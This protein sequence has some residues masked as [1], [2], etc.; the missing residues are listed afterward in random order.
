LALHGGNAPLRLQNPDWKPI[1]HRRQIVQDFTG[2]RP[3]QRK[4][5]LR[6]LWNLLCKKDKNR[7]LGTQD[8]PGCRGGG[9]PIDPREF[10]KRA[11][12]EPEA[13]KP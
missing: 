12:P 1:L 2:K 7:Y 4:R 5:E 10:R 9:K 6:A 13:V 8:A 11:M 3:I